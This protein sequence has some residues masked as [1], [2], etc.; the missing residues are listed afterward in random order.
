M[1]DVLC[2]TFPM[3]F[4]MVYAWL[5]EACQAEGNKNEGVLSRRTHLSE[6]VIQWL[7]VHLAA[8]HVDFFRIEQSV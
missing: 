4:F 2:R 8:P 3:S 1:G 5:S 7:H 6:I